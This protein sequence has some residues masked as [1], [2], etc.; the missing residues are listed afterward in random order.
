MSGNFMKITKDILKKQFADANLK[1]DDTVLI[2]SAM[3][4]IGDVEGGAETFFQALEEYFADGLIAFPTLTWK[5]GLEGYP[6]AGNVYSVKDSPTDISLL[7]ELFRQREGVVRSLLP[8]HS[9]TAKGRDAAEFCKVEPSKIKSSLPWDSPWGRLYERNAK[10]LFVG[11]TIQSCTFFHAVEEKAGIDGLFD[12]V[13]KHV[14]IIDY[15]GRETEIDMYR[16]LGAHS[17]YYRLPEALLFAEGALTM[18]TLGEAKTYVLDARKACD[19]IL[20]LLKVVPQFFMD[21][22]HQD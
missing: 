15:D 5:I 9:L 1:H 8:T 13:P 17:K 19:A 2:H 10:I 11:C 16:H 6:Q 18:T 4:K 20:K 21:S 14:K 3:K 7:P 12:P 22:Y